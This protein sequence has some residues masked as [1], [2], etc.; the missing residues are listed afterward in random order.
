MR[1]FIGYIITIGL[2]IVLILFLVSGGGGKKSGHGAAVPKLL[3][4]YAYTD[5]EVRLVL[6]GPINADENHQTIDITVDS[7]DATYTQTQGYDGT[8]VNSQTFPNTQNSY[9]AFLTALMQEDYTA[10]TSLTGFNS[11]TGLCPLGDRYNFE[12]IQNGQMLQNYWSTTCGGVATFK[13]NIP[14]TLDL[15]EAQIPNY[16]SLSASVAL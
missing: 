13:G 10:G 11:D 8:V 9:Y 14:S 5:A 16:D 4:S 1:Y 6:D 3:N 15:F 12:I 7:L 2:L